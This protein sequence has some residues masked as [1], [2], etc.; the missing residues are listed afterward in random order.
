MVRCPKKKDCKHRGLEGECKIPEIGKEICGAQDLPDTMR[1][2]Y[3][4][5]RKEGRQ[6][7]CIYC[8]E[9]LQVYQNQHVYY[10]W[11]WNERKKCFERSAEDGDSDKP[12]CACCEISDWDFIDEDYSDKPFISY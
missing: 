11:E 4:L 6:P 5:A 12:F 1:E 8:G 10:T 9:P 3:K 2:E 7:R